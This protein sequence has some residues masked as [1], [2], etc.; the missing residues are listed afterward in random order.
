MKA[1][2]L[3]TFGNADNFAIMLSRRLDVRKLVTTA[4]NRPETGIR[5]P[6]EER[7]A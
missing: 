1:V 4:G 7:L 3:K 5:L 2:V 6:A